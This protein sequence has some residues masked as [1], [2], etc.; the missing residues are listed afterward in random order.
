[1]SK[2]SILE[3]I[4]SLFAR[5]DAANG[6]NQSMVA[7][8]ESLLGD[9]IITKDTNIKH[10]TQHVSHVNV[11]KVV[12]A[13]E[14]YRAEFVRQDPVIFMSGVT[15]SEEEQK[16]NTL[17]KFFKD[18]LDRV[19][20]GAIRLTRDQVESLLI[21][22]NQ[23][24]S[25]G[26]ITE[27][28]KIFTVGTTQEND[29]SSFNTLGRDT[30][31]KEYVRVFLS[32]LKNDDLVEAYASVV[33]KIMREQKEHY[34]MDK[35]LA[36]TKNKFKILESKYSKI[37]NKDEIFGPID[38]HP[39]HEEFAEI[40]KITTLESFLDRL[41]DGTLDK[42]LNSPTEFIGHESMSKLNFSSLGAGIENEEISTHLQVLCILTTITDS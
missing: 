21:G 18:G 41:T 25:D 37:L 12:T 35:A 15:E 5:I 30:N 26:C 32:K 31:Y 28:G 2:S 17:V 19:R 42:F 36:Y 40:L 27:I 10:F 6:V 11:D 13:L 9:N 8:I 38:T 4:D 22:Y 16:L 24:F 29:I 34:S 14:N 1:M 39:H 33:Y 3:N 20:E 23:F 7:S